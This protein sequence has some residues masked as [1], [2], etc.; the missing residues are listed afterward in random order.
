MRRYHTC[1]WAIALEKRWTGQGYENVYRDDEEKT[2]ATTG[3]VI[4]ICPGCGEFILPR[5]LNANPPVPVAT[6][7]QE[8][9][10]TLQEQRDQLVEVLQILTDKIVSDGMLPPAYLV[11]EWRAARAVLAGVAQIH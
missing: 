8:Y 2:S 3:K 4:V 6:W 1:G 10:E 11:D 9:V 7:P 5:D